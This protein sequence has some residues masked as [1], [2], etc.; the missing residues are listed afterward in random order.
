MYEGCQ[1]WRFEMKRMSF[2]VSSYFI[3]C[4]VLTVNASEVEQKET[5][6]SLV[7]KAQAVYAEN[8]KAIDHAYQSSANLHIRK[9][10]RY[11]W[12]PTMLL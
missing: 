1:S 4:V 10:V 2:F 8:I 11:A 3:A 12:I 6:S 7:C 5:H 9:L